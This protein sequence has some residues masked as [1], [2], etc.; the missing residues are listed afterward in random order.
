MTKTLTIKL[1]HPDGGQIRVNAD[2]AEYWKQNGWREEPP[3]TAGK[4]GW[5][6]AP[7]PPK[8]RTNPTEVGKGERKTGVVKAGDQENG[9]D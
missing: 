8:P 9:D 2:R 6:P 4:A 1:H 5:K 3:T 7:R